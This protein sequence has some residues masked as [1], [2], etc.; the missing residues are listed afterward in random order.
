MTDV[1]VQ[2]CMG[3]GCRSP[4]SKWQHLGTDEKMKKRRDELDEKRS[5][6]SFAEKNIN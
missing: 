5:L 6:N 2:A 4:I 1:A 3:H